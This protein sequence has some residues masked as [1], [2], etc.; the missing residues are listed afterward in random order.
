MAVAPSSAIV[1]AYCKRMLNKNGEEKKLVCSH[2]LFGMTGNVN[3]NITSEYNF[4]LCI[5]L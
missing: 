5:S 4:F 3:K 2:H 1:L